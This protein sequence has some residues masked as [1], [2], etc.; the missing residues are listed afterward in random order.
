MKMAQKRASPIYWSPPVCRMTESF[1]HSTRPIY[2]RRPSLRWHDS[3]RDHTH[4][5][6]RS[7]SGVACLGTDAY[8]RSWH[9]GWLRAT[10]FN[11]RCS[12]SAG[13]VLRSTRDASDSPLGLIS[14][15]VCL[16]DGGESL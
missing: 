16:P 14:H 6:Y 9:R 2:A 10:L 11:G 8:G 4:R 13:G 3:A 1:S 7:A 12:V 15:Y 5:D